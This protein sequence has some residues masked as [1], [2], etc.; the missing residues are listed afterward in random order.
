M[1][2]ISRFY[3][4][5]QMLLMMALACCPRAGLAA[6]AGKV[7]FAVGHVT[8]Q[9]ADGRSRSL[10]KGAEI[11]AGDTI[12]T[13]DGR[14]QLKFADGGYISLSTDTAFRIDE[15]RYEGKTDGSEKGFFSLLKGGLRAITGA[16]GHIHKEAYL[17]NT[18]VATIGIRGTEFLAK[19][20]GKLVVKVGDGAVYLSNAMGDLMLYKGQSGEVGG[21][22][23]KPQH[24]NETPVVSAAG[25]KG[26]TPAETQAELANRN[27]QAIYVVGENAYDS[28][29]SCA[30]L[31]ICNPVSTTDPVSTAKYAIAPLTH[32]NWNGSNGAYESEL[33]FGLTLSKDGNGNIG[34]ISSG[35]W[36]AEA[37]SDVTFDSNGSY[38]T[39]SWGRWV[40]GHVQVTD[41]TTE[42]VEL[43]AAHIIYGAM[44]PTTDMQHLATNHLVGTYS[45]VGYTTPTLTDMASGAT[46][47]V[48]GSVTGV[49][50]ANFGTGSVN[51][52]LAAGVHSV[53]GASGSFSSPVFYV[54]KPLEIGTFQ[55]FGVFSG[56]NAAQAGMSYKF[57]YGGHVAVT[58]VAAFKQD[59]L[60]PASM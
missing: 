45:V 14:A 51:L 38:G 3:R 23:Q 28:S 12:Q 19:L 31:G 53:A 22:D 42:L 56:G 24:S 49:L 52:S 43:K 40:G 47:N 39:L 59:T 20:D 41:T 50:T 34:K 26:A 37:Q 6:S 13:G 5:N 54:S 35:S 18:P 1:S 32:V 36:M 55:A 33:D 2:M 60:A 44:T 58:G 16:V 25:P 15:Y 11:N 27:S 21:K 9:G 48:G 4:I 29:T 8:A 10:T 17:V 30:A 46:S 7:E 57:D